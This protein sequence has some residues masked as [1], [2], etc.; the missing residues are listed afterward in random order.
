MRQAFAMRRI[1]TRRDILVF[2]LDHRRALV[3]A[4]DSAGGIGPKS[5]D[6][7]CVT[8]RVVGKFTARVAL[9]EAL[10]VGATPFCVAN[11]LSVEPIPTGNEIIEGVRRELKAAGLSVPMVYS[12]EKN[13]HVKQTGVGVTVL[14]SA[15]L[16]TLKMGRCKLG[17]AVLAVGMPLVGREVLLG[18]KKGKIADTRDI[19]TLQTLPSVH[20]ILPVG[21]RG[22]SAE[23][24]NLARDSHLN[25]KLLRRV[26]VDVK[27]SAGPSTVVLCAV[28]ASIL[29]DVRSLVSKPS[30]L[31]GTL[32]E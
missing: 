22:I 1:S 7:L 11:T 27:K 29:E 17:D 10:S 26:S 14:A 3:V 21:S 13:F 5:L 24:H 4:C 9:M 6:S 28:P 23:A 30:A 25:F 31:I 19:K 16:S 15:W 12:T 20:E 2:K 32:A 18:E 8:G